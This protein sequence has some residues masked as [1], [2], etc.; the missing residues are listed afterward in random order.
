M[1]DPK[2]RAK[3]LVSELADLVPYGPT[4]PELA[5]DAVDLECTGEDDHDPDPCPKCQRIKR[6]IVVAIRSLCRLA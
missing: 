2:D 4:S 6:R 1:A 5:A 3:A